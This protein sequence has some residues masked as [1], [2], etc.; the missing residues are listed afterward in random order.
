MFAV[1]VIRNVGDHVMVLRPPIVLSVNTFEM[2]SIVWPNVRC[3][4]M[5]GMERV[6][7]VTKLAPVALDQGTQLEK[8]D[9]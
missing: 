7:I 4:N 2:A 3:Q 8:M 6:S 1:N 9:V 5:H